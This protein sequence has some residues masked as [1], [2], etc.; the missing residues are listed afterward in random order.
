MLKLK[1]YPPAVPSVE[2]KR[3]SM[4]GLALP[5]SSGS[6]LKAELIVTE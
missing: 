4:S 3:K 5:E 2:S 1:M 6:P